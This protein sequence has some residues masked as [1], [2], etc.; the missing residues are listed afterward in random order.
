MGLLIT[1]GL[2]CGLGHIFTA[3]YAFITVFVSIFTTDLELR[4]WATHTAGLQAL[5]LGLWPGALIVF[6]LGQALTADDTFIAVELAVRRARLELRGWAARTTTLQTLFF[7]LRRCA[8]AAVACLVEIAEDTFAVAGRER[9]IGEFCGQL[10]DHLLGDVAV[11]VGADDQVT[12]SA[13][14]VCVGGA[15][16]PLL[17]DR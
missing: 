8:H 13:P 14:N 3:H 15:V 2:V 12:I 6:D 9:F 7:R 10:V 17:G 5:F 4:S 16:E 1:A 11:I